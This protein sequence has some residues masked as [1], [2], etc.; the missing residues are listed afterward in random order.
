M[1][2]IYS[3]LTIAIIGLGAM[4]MTSCSEDQE[5]GMS[6]EGTWV[7]SMYI[8]MEYSGHIYK[9]NE[10]E[11]TFTSDPFRITKG[12]GYWVDY[13]DKYGHNRV[14]NRIRWNV[15]GRTITIHFIDDGGE[16]IIDDFRINNNHFEGYIYDDFG[17]PTKFELTKVM[18]DDRDWDDY[19]FGWD[20]RYGD[21]DYY[22]TYSW[23]TRAAKADDFNMVEEAQKTEKPIRHVMSQNTEIE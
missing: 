1:K 10:S 13:Y 4:M 21:W 7:G 2:K 6:L 15:T 14:A 12:Y 23:S 5:I 17:K 19:E 20:N 16:I 9:T 11:I 3:M 8:Q 22:Y 18:D